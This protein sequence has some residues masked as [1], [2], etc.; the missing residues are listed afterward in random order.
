MEDHLGGIGCDKNPLESGIVYSFLPA[1]KSL[2]ANLPGSHRVCNRRKT[3]YFYPLRTTSRWEKSVFT[4]VKHTGQTGHW[5]VSHLWR[6]N[7]NH[8]I[9]LG[10]LNRWTEKKLVALVHHFWPEGFRFTC[11]PVNANADAEKEHLD[12]QKFWRLAS[13]LCSWMYTQCVQRVMALTEHF[14]CQN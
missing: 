6:K 3:M 10:A 14:V 1:Q 5:N 4:R 11:L 2:F 12:P 13:S 7:H 9:P 8:Y